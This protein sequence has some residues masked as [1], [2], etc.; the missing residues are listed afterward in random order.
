M[1]SGT[2]DRVGDAKRGAALLRALEEEAAAA[3]AAGEAI[4]SAVT[5]WRSADASSAHA[6]AISASTR[7]ANAAEAINAARIALAIDVPSSLKD[8][9]QLVELQAEIKADQ[10]TTGLSKRTMADEVTALRSAVAKVETV[11]ASCN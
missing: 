5:A 2:L 1:I 7:Y 11:A 9:P 4:G 3:T 8:D 6:A 10:A